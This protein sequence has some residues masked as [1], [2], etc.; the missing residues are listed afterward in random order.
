MNVRQFA[1]DCVFVYRVWKYKH[2]DSNNT[3]FW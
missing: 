1:H 2:S 3:L